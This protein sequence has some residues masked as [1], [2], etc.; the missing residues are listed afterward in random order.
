MNLVSYLDCSYNGFLQRR[1]VEHVSGISYNDFIQKNLLIPGGIT[2]AIIDADTQN[3]EL[4]TSF[5]ND[6]VNDRAIDIEFSGW[7]NPTAN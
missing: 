7:V 1:M 5:N 2:N 6:F 4:V 3:P